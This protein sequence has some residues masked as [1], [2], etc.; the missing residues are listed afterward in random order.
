MFKKKYKVLRPFNHNVVLCKKDDKE[1][2]LIGKGIGFG[3]KPGDCISKVDNIEKEFFLVSDNNKENFKN[4]TDTVDENI[5]GVTEEAIA[6][7]SKQFNKEL[8]EKIHV[9]LPDHIAFSLKRL[10]NGIEVKN[11]LLHEIK[12]LYK[13]EFE[14]AEEILITIN[15]R[16]NVNLSRDEIGFIAM[17]I[18]A[19]ITNQD[20]SK[21]A[22]DTAIITDMIKFIDQ[23]INNGLD[24]NS[25]EYCR[26]LTHL[27]F[28]LER[29]R[30]NS[31]IENILISTIKENYKDTYEIAERLAKMIEEEYN[32]IF[33]E[34]E[35][36]YLTIHLQNILTNS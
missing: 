10:Q 19:A 32:I 18:H 25:L 17:H 1:C 24:K 9:T 5:I 13:E 22:M 20:V 2:I 12:F 27:R 6:K 36:G 14:A 26:L 8:N 35:I 3:V 34:G 29:V 33:P 21:S 7:I 16:L 15:E 28:A 11:V 4:L 31:N 30:N 23:N